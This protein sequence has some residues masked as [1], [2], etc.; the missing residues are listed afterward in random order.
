MK[1]VNTFAVSYFV[2]CAFK[3]S[4]GYLFYT[5]ILRSISVVSMS[6]MSYFIRCGTML[7][8]TKTGQKQQGWIDLLGVA[9]HRINYYNYIG[10]NSIY[11]KNNYCITVKSD[12]LDWQNVNEKD[13]L[14]KSNSWKTPSTPLGCVHLSEVSVRHVFLLFPKK[15]CQM[16]LP[17][18]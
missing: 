11:L 15:Y 9:P 6:K 12:Q 18:W 5:L 1:R 17:W 3:S 8:D 4:Y 10:L 14:G 2:I 7:Y 13:I 16:I